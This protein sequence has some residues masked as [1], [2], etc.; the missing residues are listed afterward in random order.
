M[1]PH[2]VLALNRAEKEKFIRVTVAYPSR[3]GVEVVKCRALPT[4]RSS[5]RGALLEAAAADAYGRLIEP[6]V[7][8]ELRRRLTS[9]R[10]VGR[11]VMCEPLHERTA[12]VTDSHGVTESH[13]PS[14]S[15]C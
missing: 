13:E 2:R 8:R 11:V 6:S 15:G 10:A 9:V 12:N 14:R 1:P 3:E 7:I 4:P 5:A